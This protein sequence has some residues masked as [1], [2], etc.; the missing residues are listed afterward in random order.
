A[1]RYLRV[2]ESYTPCPPP[3]TVAGPDPRRGAQNA[4][5]RASGGQSFTPTGIDGPMECL[6]LMALDFRSQM[7]PAFAMLPSYADWLMNTQME[8]T[9]LYQRRVLKLLHWGETARSWRL[10]SPA[11]L[12][13]LP[14]LDTAF[15]GARFVMTHRDPTA[16][17]LS[18]A[19]VYSEIA[20]RFSDALD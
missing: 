6:D 1:I 20:A 12:L 15:P 3:S 17:I 11:H 2:W 9:Y 19:T 10:K 8:C 18:I 16:V 5:D 14:D 4:V 13:F 7:F